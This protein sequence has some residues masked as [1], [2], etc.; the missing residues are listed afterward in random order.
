MAWKIR[1]PLSKTIDGETVLRHYYEIDSY[2]ESISE[3]NWSDTIN[4]E[5]KTIQEALNEV[6]DLIKSDK[7]LK[8]ELN[9]PTFKYTITLCEETESTIWGTIYKCYMYKGQLRIKL[10]ED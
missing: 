2:C 4:K 3:E 7:E 9:E 10:L 1:I 8:K 6:Q 5:F